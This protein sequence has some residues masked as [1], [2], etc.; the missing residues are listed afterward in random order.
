MMTRAQRAR[1]ALIPAPFAI[2]GITAGLVGHGLIAVTAI[3]CGC[4]SLA[5]AALSVGL[6][7]TNPRW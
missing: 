4:V 6:I 2:F 7:L 1:R 5:F 3:V